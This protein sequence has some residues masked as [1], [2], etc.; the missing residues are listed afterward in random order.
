MG[1]REPDRQTKSKRET[2]TGEKDSNSKL[3]K[4]TNLQIAKQITV[5]NSD[6]NS[7]VSRRTHSRLATEFKANI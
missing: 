3:C 6:N 4:S 1:E 2:E 5:L 7:A